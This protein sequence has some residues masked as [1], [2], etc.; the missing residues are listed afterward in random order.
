MDND[1]LYTP[2]ET[3]AKPKISKYTVY[4]MIKRG[5]IEAHHIGRHL[6]VS[7][8]QLEN[9]MIKTMWRLERILTKP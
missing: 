2:E 7:N 5:D 6:R 9:Y 1:I 8:A 3:A 4:E